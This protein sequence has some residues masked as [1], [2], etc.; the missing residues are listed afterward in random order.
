MHV[1]RYNL[2]P[3]PFKGRVQAAQ[4]HIFGC[5]HKQDASSVMRLSC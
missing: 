3:L 5:C 1:E 4:Q 2:Y